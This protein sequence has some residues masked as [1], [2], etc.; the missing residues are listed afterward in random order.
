MATGDSSDILSRVKQIIPYSWFSYVAPIR[1]AV[2]GGLSDAAAWCYSWITYATMQTRIL[3]ATGPW[4]DIIANDFLGRNLLR[5]GA[6][7]NT[8]RA[9]IQ[10]TILQERVTRSGMANAIQKLVGVAP[11]IFEPWSP[12]DAGA[13]GNGR[14]AY[15]R[16]G[17]WGSLQLPGQVFVQISRNALSPSGIP[18]AVGY[19]GYGGGY[20]GGSTSYGSAELAASSVAQIGVTDDLIYQ[21]INQTK[22]SGVICWTQ[23]N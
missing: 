7:D 15:G 10:A 16:S 5:N 9:T 12:Q 17:G 14:F 21:V 11:V 6:D 18:N 19:G 2:L 3:S 1:D 8:F 20:Y 13:Y 22:P 4:L 23:I